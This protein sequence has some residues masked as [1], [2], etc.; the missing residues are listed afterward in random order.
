MS[1]Y[2]YDEEEVRRVLAEEYAQEVAQ[3]MAKELVESH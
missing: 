2:D 3:G 1:I